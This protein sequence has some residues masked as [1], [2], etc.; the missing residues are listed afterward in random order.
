MGANYIVP[1]A[2]IRTE[3][4]RGSQT[5]GSLAEVRA[6]WEFPTRAADH[7]PALQAGTCWRPEPTREG[8]MQVR[9]VLVATALFVVAGLSAALARAENVVRWATIAGPAGLD[10]QAH[11]DAPTNALMSQVFE[12]LVCR[13][14]NEAP[15]P[16][17]AESWKML[18]P[19][20][21][22]FRLRE[23]V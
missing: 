2:E 23:G 12:D 11:N 9:A 19:L 8:T 5:L 20:T 1:L 17:L 14:L 16:C 10:P 18:D 4:R 6:V 22:E 3:C 7:C 21:W 13:G 15:Q